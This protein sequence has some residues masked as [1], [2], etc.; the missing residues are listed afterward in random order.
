[1]KMN[2]FFITLCCVF[3]LGINAQNTEVRYLSGTGLG[4]TKTWDFYCSAGMNS[5]KWSK[6][7]V[8]SVWEQQ[9][10]GAY[11]YGRF[12]LVK[13]TQPSDENGLYRYKF[14]VPADWK[15]KEV[16]I[17][18][19][20]VM[21]DA[22]VKINRT[23]A[24]EIHQ[25]AFYRFSYDITDKLKYGKKNELEVK[26]WKESA[27]RSVN[28]A[29]R[30][31][32]WW[33][34]GGIYRP[35][36]LKAV[37]KTHIERIAVNA[38]ADGKLSTDLYAKNLPEGFSLATSLR[39]VDGK[40]NLGKQ[41]NTLHGKDVQTISTS[42]QNVRN[43]DCEHP[44]LYTLR[45]ELLNPQKQ[46]VHVHEERIGF[47]TI[48]FRPKDG[49]YLNDTKI[50]LRGTN[51]H[52]FH[53][54]G[55]RT[56]NKEL[57]VQDA[58][59]IKKMNMNAVRSHYPPDK[60]FLDVCDSLGLFYLDELA[61]W[62]NSY[63]AEVGQKLLAEMIAH[64][65]NHPC[66]FMWSNG[67]EGGWNTALDSLF[68]AYDPQKRHVIHPWADF[69]G[70]DTHHYP[71]YQTGTYRLANGYNV[72]MPTEFLH[73]LYD[74]GHGAGLDDFWSNYTSSPLFAG[75]F[76]WAYVDEAVKR[77]DTGKLDSDGPNGPDGIVGPWREE[78]GSFYTV[79]EVWAPIQ[80]KNLY[81]TP[82]FK[83]D[84]MVSNTHLFTNLKAC[85]MKYRLYQTPSPLLGAK[86]TLTAEGTVALPTL[87]PGET[88]VAHMELP[89]HFFQADVLEL[90][91][92]DQQGKSLCNWTWPVKYAKEYFETQRGKV[93]VSSKA[94]MA[95][96]G[97]KVVL[98]AGGVSAAFDSQEGTLT[99][100]KRNEQVIPLNNGPIPVG[101]K[102]RFKEGYTCMEGN[103]ALYVVKY[104]GAIDS[105]VWRMTGDGLLGMDA[106]IFNRPTGG[107]FGEAFFDKEVY[108]FGLSFSFPEEEVKAMRWMGRGP[109]RV[110]KNRIK[111]TNY[112]IWEKAYNNTITGENFENLV[113][114]EFKGYHAN[115]Y[116]A[117]LESDRVPFT[118]YSESDG[119]FFRVFTPEEPVQR[120]N[121]E[122]TM[123]EFPSGDISFL[124]DIPAMR[125][126]KS[127]PELGP[128]SQ[129]STIRLK[130]GDDGFRMKLWFDFRQP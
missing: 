91:A 127:I 71:A 84:F 19:E 30:R 118:V 93:G 15:D 81:I 126:G 41:V 95:S 124:Y 122:N 9:G 83:G 53:P 69:N 119:L 90:E 89:P 74:R 10:F 37:P 40:Q 107:G 28:A 8:P 47:R 72:F 108:N 78:E 79:R 65:V 114:P 13:G 39:S 50:I 77:T 80:F 100:I 51:R 130:K 3:A 105:I 32:D 96:I 61:G 55:G 58:L 76:L 101:M 7:E 123:R 2:Y 104:L 20:G 92:Y 42:W 33:L 36:Y 73:G 82:S 113:Y 66:I 59:L 110:W 11:T 54:E 27:R 102:V 88:G 86:Q 87:N 75:G 12:Y 63:D 128:K 97:G 56:T 25:G 115:M 49:I 29:E 21:T 125:S 57:S 48:E 38:T 94:G 26:V 6:I 85:R 4:H 35:V 23:L 1:M 16:S 34:F 52:C 116:W 44:N 31:A 117:T 106:V 70:L 111:G 45:L 64:D 129:P 22:E 60:H 18:F 99:E 67:N 43:W 98:S 103:D 5:A 17:V 46:I 68:A 120:R 121:G 24:G 112:G 109:Y 62:Q 14:N